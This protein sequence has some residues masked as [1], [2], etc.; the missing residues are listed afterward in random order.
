MT[1]AS[2]ELTT[3]LDA[4]LHSKERGRKFDH[5]DVLVLL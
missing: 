3:V 2:G 1:L 4:P 5:E